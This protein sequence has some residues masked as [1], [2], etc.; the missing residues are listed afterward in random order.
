MDRRHAFFSLI[1]DEEVLLIVKEQI[2]SRLAFYSIMGGFCYRSASSGPGVT[3]DIDLV[4]TYPMISKIAS[5]PVAEINDKSKADD[6]AKIVT[7]FQAAWILLQCLGRRLNGLPITI[8]ELNTVLHVLNAIVM[9]SLWWRKPL[10]VDMPSDI[11]GL[12]RTQRPVR[13]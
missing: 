13:Q 6:L 3:L 9:Y 1:D 10:D 4:S 7:V 8:L 12:T 11:G 2:G 5:Y